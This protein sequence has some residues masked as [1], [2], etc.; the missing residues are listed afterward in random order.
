MSISP[1]EL[2]IEGD[3]QLAVIEVEGV[4][5][6]YPLDYVIHHHIINDRFGDK[7]ISLTYCAMCRS[8]IPFDVTD[9]GPL[10]VASFKNANMIVADQKTKTFIQQATFDSVI[11]KIHPYTLTM[12]P[13]QILTWEQLNTLEKFPQVAEVT[14]EDFKP[15]SLPIPGVWKKVMSSELTPGLSKK[16]TSMPSKT[17]VIGIT[18]DF[19][20]SDIAYLKERVQKFIV[21]KNEEHNFSLF[22]KDGAVNA[23]RNE[24]NGQKLEFSMDNKFIYD[25]LSNNQWDLLGKF[26]KG[27]LNV[28]LIRVAISDEYWFSWKKFHPNTQLIEIEL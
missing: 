24:V 20:K 7:I 1:K 9:I 12:I 4:T 28:D 21:V 18:D 11:G 10:F 27:D 25:E 2:P 19:V 8:I 6:A 22:A 5:K 14:L 26:N 13:F 16:D 15:F 23:F 17:H 3:Q